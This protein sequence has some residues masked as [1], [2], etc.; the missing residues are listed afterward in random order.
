[1]GCEISTSPGASVSPSKADGWEDKDPGIGDIRG[2]RAHGGFTVIEAVIVQ[3]DSN[4]K[5]FGHFWHGGEGRTVSADAEENDIAEGRIIGD[6]TTLAD[7]TV[8][9]SIKTQYEDSEG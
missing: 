7:P 5:I 8:L 2:G 4:I 9:A 6:T 3:F 1:M